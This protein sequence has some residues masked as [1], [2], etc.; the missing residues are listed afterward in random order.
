MKILCNIG[1]GRTTF[2]TDDKIISDTDYR[3]SKSVAT[4]F[5][6]EVKD[7]KI[8]MNG[9][10]EHAIIDKIDFENNIIYATLTDDILDC[11]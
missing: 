4:V 11:L 9:E 1:E 6:K 5:L 2:L 10:G 3:F 7:F 8:V